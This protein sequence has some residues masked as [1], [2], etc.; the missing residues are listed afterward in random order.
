MLGNSWAAE[1]L[2]V[3]HEEFG[4]MELLTAL[5]LAVR[6]ILSEKKKKKLSSIE[7]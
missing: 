1:R 3:S 2:V 6:I 5:F 4:F 7:K